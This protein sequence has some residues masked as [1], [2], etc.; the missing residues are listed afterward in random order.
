MGSGKTTLGRALA[1]AT[2][3][4]FVDL[5]EAIQDDARMT[6][7]QIFAAEGEAG[8]RRRETDMLRVMATRPAIVACGG[9]TPLQPGNMELMNSCG[10]TVWLR[11]SVD[12][13]TERLTLYPGDRPLLRGLSGDALRQFITDALTARTPHYSQARHTFDANSLDTAAQIERSTA[14]FIS[15]YLTD[16]ESDP[17]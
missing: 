4:P 9:G 1:A 16:N 17:T 13:L 5:D 6:V 7:G 10:R 8:F 15:K 12:R 3:L 14:L 11:A 2:G